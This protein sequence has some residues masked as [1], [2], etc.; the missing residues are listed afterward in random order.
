MK[1]RA[2]KHAQQAR[3]CMSL[4][5][6][7]IT[8]RKYVIKKPNLSQYHRWVTGTN[9]K[10]QVT[11]NYKIQYWPETFYG[12][13]LICWHSVFIWVWHC[14]GGCRPGL[15]VAGEAV[16]NGFG[17]GSCPLWLRSVIKNSIIPRVYCKYWPEEIVLF[18]QV[19]SVIIIS[20]LLTTH[21]YIP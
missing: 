9:R 3:H 10:K 5:L 11:G 19:V 1:R 7:G 2:G 15:E 8:K 6:R 14:C 20:I 16:P 18:C 4:I 17:I 21:I 12:C 13:C